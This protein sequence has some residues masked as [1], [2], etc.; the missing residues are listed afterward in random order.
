[1]QQGKQKLLLTLLCIAVAVTFAFAPGGR[2]ITDKAGSNYTVKYEKAGN[3]PNTRILLAQD[4]WGKFQL[5]EMR[6]SEVFWSIPF[7]ITLKEVQRIDTLPDGYQVQGLMDYVWSD[8]P[9]D[10]VIAFRINSYGHLFS[11]RFPNAELAPVIPVGIGN[12]Q[13]NIFRFEW[14]SPSTDGETYN[15]YVGPTLTQL[16]IIRKDLFSRSAD[17]LKE[18]LKGMPTVYWQVEANYKYGSS[19]M[20]PIAAFL[21]GLRK[22]GPITE[23]GIEGIVKDANT[24]V[25]LS[26]V[27]LQLFSS[28]PSASKVVT[29]DVYGIFKVQADAGTGYA[30]VASKAGYMDAPYRD[31]T[32][33]SGQKTYLEPILH[34]DNRYAGLGTIEGW[35]RDAA[36]GSR[37]LG[38]TKILV[39][40]GIN[41][42]TGTVLH[43]GFSSS[44]GS[45]ILQNIPAGNYT[46]EF[47]ASGYVNNFLDAVFLGG[48]T[49]TECNVALSPISTTP[50]EIR[51]VLSW[52]VENLDLDAHLT[53]PLPDGKQFHMFH[54]LAESQGKS[55]WP[56]YVVL[57][58]DNRSGWDGP[59]TIT[60][61]TPI[62]GIYRY[63]V[64]DYSNREI[65]N[66]KTLSQSS[67]VVTVFQGG[68]EIGRF[69]V[70]ANVEGSF[71][72][73][74]EIQMDAFAQPIIYPFN[75]FTDLYNRVWVIEDME[76]FP[77]PILTT[78]P[79]NWQ[80]QVRAKA[81][82]VSSTE[83]AEFVESMGMDPVQ[84]KALRFNL[85][86]GV[87]LDPSSVALFVD[88]EPRGVAVFEAKMV[89]TSADLMFVVDTTGSMGEEIEG[90]KNSLKEF[91]S[92]LN[93][94]GFDARVGFLPYDDVVPSSYLGISPNWQNLTSYQETIQF[95]DKVLSLNGGN[96]IPYT[97]IR[98]ALDNGD[99]SFNS[100]QTIVLVTDERSESG[101]QYETISKQLLIE[102]IIG[103]ALVHS[104]ISTQEGEYSQSETNYTALDDPREIS[105]KTGGIIAY[106]D[107]KGNID[108]TKTGILE[109]SEGSS[110][111]MFP[112]D[113]MKPGKKVDIYFDTSEGTGFLSLPAPTI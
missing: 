16:K 93:V 52:N 44:D 70:P 105:P 69:P 38:G 99:W 29:T 91:I 53:G 74:F 68:K 89:K 51:I 63:T 47:E 65:K 73:V 3:S 7:P 2:T 97:A 82:P 87:Q 19:L 10:E 71:W 27:K 21:S 111:L 79:V 78:P 76:K 33:V 39:R 86:A 43:T 57:D 60:I 61:K 77:A 42:R 72:N 20:S 55:P 41:Q 37:R 103:K 24:G 94:I 9:L 95:I 109:F 28:G 14:F 64:R 40:L 18:E 112:Y 107:A 30:L 11:Y 1:M 83:V 101:S 62:E 17:V 98:Y 67:A 85:P 113:A 5:F 34:I 88:N 106:T 4:A 12:P 54:P 110:Y 90:V 96:E 25:P 75:E 31:I 81:V 102:K 50:E 15:L 59:E 66:C 45:Y 100:D 26:G 22:R 13:G 46:L 48:K 104:I 56:N 108:L 84:I 92:Y 35:V 80:N 8:S 49:R 58:P 23:S 32:V 6:G 36:T